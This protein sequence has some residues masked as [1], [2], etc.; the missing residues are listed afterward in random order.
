VDHVLLLLEMAWWDQRT[1]RHLVLGGVLEQNPGLQVVFTEDGMGWI[2]GQLQAMD[3]FFDSMRTTTAASELAYGAQVANGLSARPSEYWRRQCYV[4]AS[5][6]QPAE[7]V[8]ASQ[9]GTDRIMWGSDYPHIES[10]YPYSKQAIRLA[11][12]GQPASD[13]ARMLSGNAASLF[14]F[15]LGKLRSA[16]DRV[17]PRLRD[18]AAGIHPDSLPVGAAKCPAFAGIMPGSAQTR[19]GDNRQA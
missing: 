2:P 14:G 12:A 6:M 8:I 10:S 15:D 11:Y 7:T 9:V 19:W 13:V 1:L 4:G 3:S 5:F 16:A 17:G 18:V